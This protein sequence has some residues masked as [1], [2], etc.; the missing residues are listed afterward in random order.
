MKRAI[1]F[2]SGGLFGLA[3]ALGAVPYVTH[4]ALELHPELMHLSLA[5]ALASRHFWAWLF[6]FHPTVV[7]IVLPLFF[8]FL[9]TLATRTRGKR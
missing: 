6:L 8:S 1:G 3:V 9:G 2:I 5:E 4:V 7:N